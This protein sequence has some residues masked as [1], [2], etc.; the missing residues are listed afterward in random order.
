MEYRNLGSSGLKVST[1]CLGT[2][3]FG[4][5]IDSAQSRRI[6]DVAL[7]EGINFF[8]TANVYGTGMDNGDLTQHGNSEAILGE[9]LQGRRHEAVVATKVYGRVGH[10]PNDAGLSRRHIFDQVEQS[11]RRLRTDYIDL[12]QCHR[13]DPDTPLEETLSAMTDLVQAGK[14]RYFGVSN[15]DAWQICRALWIAERQGYTRV[16]SVQPQYSLLHRAP[17][18]E[19]F[20]FCLDQGVGAIAYSPLAR[21]VLAGKYKRG[22]AY[23]EGSRAKAGERRIMP[24]MTEQNLAIAER[25]AELAARIGRAPAELALAAV[26][27]QPAVTSAII[28]ASRAEQVTETVRGLGLHLTPELRAEIAQT[29]VEA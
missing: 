23:P 20:P 22:E 2:M 12:Y 5:W 26:L 11:L 8:D 16:I 25:L 21:G 19:L 14:V 28:G 9:L 24:L 10:G 13:F 4:R 7:A 27:D 18:Q 17:E 15:W 6:L 3:A 29:L 1:I